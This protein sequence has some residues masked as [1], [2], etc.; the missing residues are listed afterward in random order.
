MYKGIKYE[1]ISFQEIEMNLLHGAA[2]TEKV[3]LTG[4]DPTTW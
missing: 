1:E 4:A 2:Y 3:F